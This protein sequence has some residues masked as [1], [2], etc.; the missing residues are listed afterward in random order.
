MSSY[1]PGRPPIY[2]PFT[3]KGTAPPVGKPGEYRILA[4][5]GS[6]AYIGETC[7]LHRRMLEHIRSGKLSA[8]RPKMAF[9]VADG[10]SS[11]RTRR[12]HETAKIDQ[13]APPLNQVRGGGGR[14]AGR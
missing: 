8:D 4:S 7:D 10:R 12:M 5:D 3:G 13:H 2:N 1:K 14:V 6:I 11:S 9:Q